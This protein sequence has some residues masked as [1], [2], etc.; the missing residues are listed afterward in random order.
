M[1]RPWVV[2]FVLVFLGIVGVSVF[3]VIRSGDRGPMLSDEPGVASTEVDPEA[4]SAG[5]SESPPEAWTPEPAKGDPS[6]PS[7]QPDGTSSDDAPDEPAR[8]L[9]GRVI[10][11]DRDG[12][13]HPAE[14]GSLRLGIP[15]G[16]SDV[17]SHV[18]VEVTDG[19][20]SVELGARDE[21]MVS[22]MTLG[23]RGAVPDNHLRMGTQVDPDVVFVVRA[24]WLAS[25]L[26][27]VVDSRTREP[28]DGIEVRRSNH[29]GETT[30]PHPGPTPVEP[31]V[32]VDAVSPVEIVA[33]DEHFNYFHVRADGYSWIRVKLDVKG[34]ERTVELDPC[35]GLRIRLVHDGD[36]PQARLRLYEP[37]DSA[38]RVQEYVEMIRKGAREA[39]ENGELE[40]AIAQIEL[41]RASLPPE[42]AAE[43]EEDIAAFD[44]EARD[45]L[46]LLERF[47]SLVG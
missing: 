33:F 14:S 39:A 42:Q 36:V 43:V 4:E 9:R 37:V 25:T 24:S 8:I 19:E 11:V 13:E 38:A 47:L 15:E 1:S 29:R 31:A 40:E 10:V 26:L 12:D 16:P 22:D 41:A 18:E 21:I 46:D 20:W 2:A 5:R 34:G 35:G 28:L 6:P 45:T 3:L 23:G 27:H 7:A 32:H 30:G 17:F 44:L